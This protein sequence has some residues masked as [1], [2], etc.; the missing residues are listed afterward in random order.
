MYFAEISKLNPE[1]AAV[2]P[3]LRPMLKYSSSYQ[4][5]LPLLP[6]AYSKEEF[7]E[8]WKIGCL[9]FLVGIIPLAA[10]AFADKVDD[11]MANLWMYAVNRYVMA[12]HALG[13]VDFVT[14]IAAGIGLTYP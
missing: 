3:V 10:G 6:Q 11:R 13:A 2:R 4:H 14:K 7:M 1:L 9:Q 8:D 12:L 5:P